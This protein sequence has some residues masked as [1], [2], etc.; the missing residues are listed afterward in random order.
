MSDHAYLQLPVWNGP[1][2]QARNNEGEVGPRAG[3]TG[4]LGGGGR[5]A[6]PPP[7]PAEG[8]AG[9]WLGVPEGWVQAV[10]RMWAYARVLVC[11]VCVLMCMCACQVPMPSCAHMFSAVKERDAHRPCSLRI[12]AEEFSISMAFH[13]DSVLN[14]SLTI[15]SSK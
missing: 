6:M 11:C 10:P 9:R 8:V 5:P 3:C 4:A 7:C 15:I 1:L 12:R 2:E 14:F 13:G